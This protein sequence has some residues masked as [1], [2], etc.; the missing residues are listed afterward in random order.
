MTARTNIKLSDEIREKLAEL[1]RKS[2]NPSLG[3]IGNAVGVSPSTVRTAMSGYSVKWTTYSGILNVL[4]ATDEE[5]AEFRNAWIRSKTSV[6]PAT[7]GPMWAQ[8]IHTK[9]DRILEL[10]ETKSD[11]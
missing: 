3:D 9:L 6:M 5:I 4:S 11:S 10:L 8:E 1:R 2:G 7:N